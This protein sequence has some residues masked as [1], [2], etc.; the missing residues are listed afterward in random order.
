MVRVAKEAVIKYSRKA[1]LVYQ[2]MSKEMKGL[3]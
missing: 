2:F 1:S 3:S